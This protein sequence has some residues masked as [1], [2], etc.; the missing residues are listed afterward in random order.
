MS[1]A[2]GSPIALICERDN[3]A[4]LCRQ[5]SSTCVH[6]SQLPRINLLMTPDR[7][8][9]YST[10]M[11]II[12]RNETQIQTFSIPLAIGHF[13]S[14]I[15]IPRNNS[16]SQN[17]QTN[18]LVLSFTFRTSRCA[19]ETIAGN[20]SQLWN[21]I[22][23]KPALPHYASGKSQSQSQFLF[24]H[25]EKVLVRVSSFNVDHFLR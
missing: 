11:L 15:R 10:E 20:R 8:S 18:V 7:C 9:S 16:N 1:T 6:T 25:Q 14:T 12:V 3:H 4:P 22:Q 21:P 5:T 23:S 19:I 24:V 2:I 17:D 13:H